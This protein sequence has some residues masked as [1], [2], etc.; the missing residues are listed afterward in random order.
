[1]FQISVDTSDQ[2]TCN[3]EPLVRRIVSERGFNDEDFVYDI[4]YT[5][6]QQFDF[7]TFEH[8]LTLEAFNLD[9]AHDREGEEV[10]DEFVYGDDDD[11]NIEANWRNDYPDE[12]PHYIDNDRGNY[13]YDDG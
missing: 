12:D 11:E 1:M 3:S 5:N 7:R 4:Y 13:N 10:E 6:S 2:I 8:D 9:L